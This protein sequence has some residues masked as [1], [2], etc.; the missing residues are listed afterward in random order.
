VSFSV[1]AD[2]YDRFT[3]R[4]S[5]PFAPQFADFAGVA[6]GQHV[7]DAGCGYGALTVE[8]VRRMAADALCAVVSS[9]PL[10]EAVRRHAGVG[11]G[12]RRRST[13]VRGPVVR[14]VLCA[15]RLDLR[16]QMLPAA[17]FVVSA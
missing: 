4:Y 6:A 12:V 13:V 10:V 14:R 16:K 5:L 7:L 17:P 3:G 15:A 11:C 8:F 9:E 1:G 2:E